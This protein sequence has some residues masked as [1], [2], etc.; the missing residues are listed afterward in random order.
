MAASNARP[1]QRPP[2]LVFLDVDGVLHPTHGAT[3]FNPSCMSSLRTIIEK[4]GA[5]IDVAKDKD[6]VGT[7]TISGAP[8]VVREARALIDE[9]T[10]EELPIEV[11][12]TLSRMLDEV[13]V[14]T[15]PADRVGKVIGSRGAVIQRLR[16]E[17]S[18]T[19]D[20]QKDTTG[21]A[22]VTLRGSV[23]AMRAAKAAIERIVEGEDPE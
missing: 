8:P 16:Q 20:L 13:L 4:T 15:V 10:R 21:S 11:Q 14:V 5:V 2:P 9:L 12:Q 1:T 23:E 6:G 7:V 18:A 3:F 22:T 19:I 17:T